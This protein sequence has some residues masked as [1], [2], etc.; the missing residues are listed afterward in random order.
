MKTRQIIIRTMCLLMMVSA[1]TG[2]ILLPHQ[3]DGEA[4]AQLPAEVVLAPAA[5]LNR[6][7][8]DQPAQGLFRYLVNDR[9]ELFVGMGYNPI[10]RYLADKDR[11]A[12]YDRDFAILRQAGVN[13]I[14]GWD[15]DKGFEQDKFDELTLG[16]ALKHGLGVVMPFYLPPEGDYADE[17]FQRHLMEQAAT[18]IARFKDH[19]AL[20]MWGVGNE[21]LSEMSWPE[22][23]DAFLEFYVKL[24]DRFH[25]LDP[26][27][28]VIYREAEDV[29]V[30]AILSTWGSPQ[31]RP[32]L[33]YGMNSYT[34]AI[35]RLIDAWPLRSA[36]RPLFVTEF[37]LEDQGSRRRADGYLRMWQAIRSRPT[38]VLG[39]A[40]YVWTTQGPE[41]TDTIW[42]LMDDHSRPVDDTFERLSAEWRRQR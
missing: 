32:W 21:V 35:G 42:G 2:G 4:K 33:L 14:T 37:G 13:H 36:G 27:H 31:E 29:F 30:P 25:Q 12:R 38:Y 19:P 11:A 3:P 24:A 16:Q 41:P 15:A 10:Y 22:E 39:G 34:L 9:P 26:S 5:Q 17:T 8:V 18:K 7:A 20:R 28:P 23:R 40:P 1:I 6:V